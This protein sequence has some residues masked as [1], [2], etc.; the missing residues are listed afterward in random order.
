MK[1]SRKVGRGERL[2]GVVWKRQKEW[3]EEIMGTGLWVRIEG[4]VRVGE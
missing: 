2:K 1:R 3:M 4:G